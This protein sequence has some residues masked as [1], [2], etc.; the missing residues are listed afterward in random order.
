VS[1]TLCVSI[2]LRFQQ[3][4]ERSH[5]TCLRLDFFDHTHVIRSCT[6]IIIITQRTLKLSKTYC[7]MCFF[8]ADGSKIVK[9]P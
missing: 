3:C 1:C 8:V 2:V 7:E 6:I 9:A 4:G 5:Y